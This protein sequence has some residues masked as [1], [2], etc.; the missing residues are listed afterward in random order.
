MSK[1]FTLIELLI[2]IAILAILAG[3][4]ITLYYRKYLPSAIRAS[5]ISDLRNCLTQ[6]IATKQLEDNATTSEIVSNCSKSKYTQQIILESEDP[7][8]LKAVSSQRNFT[9]S[10]NE[11]SGAIS[12]SS[13][14]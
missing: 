2:V 7:L 14:F 13:V 5:L 8:Q 3:M 4:A 12:C 11:T 6:I 1:A 9:C 10:Y